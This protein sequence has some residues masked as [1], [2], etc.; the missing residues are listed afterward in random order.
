MYSIVSEE[1]SSMMELEKGGAGWRPEILVSDDLGRVADRLQVGSEDIE[2]YVFDNTLRRSVARCSPSSPYCPNRPAC[3]DHI[4][5][6]LKTPVNIEGGKLPLN[7]V[8]T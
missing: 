8:F 5:F 6:S 3:L 1:K 2:E 4:K 7:R